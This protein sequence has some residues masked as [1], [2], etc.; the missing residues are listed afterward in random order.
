MPLAHTK[1]MGARRSPGTRPF[2][3]VGRD[4]AGLTHRSAER[5]EREV[6]AEGTGADDGQRLRGTVQR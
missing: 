1:G 5:D 2:R 6:V 3:F 4:T